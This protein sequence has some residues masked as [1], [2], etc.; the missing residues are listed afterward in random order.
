MCLL[1]RCG[2][3]LFVL[4]VLAQ[5]ANAQAPS[6]KPNLKCGAYCL[7]VALRALDVDVPNYDALEKELGLPGRL[8]YSMSDLARVAELHGAHVKGM[9]TH[10]EDL[11]SR[12]Q[13]LAYICLSSTGHFVC[14]YNV[15]GALVHLV[16]PPEVLSVPVDTFKQQWTGK[17]LLISDSPIRESASIVPHGPWAWGLLIATI[18]TACLLVVLLKRSTRINRLT[19]PI[20]VILSIFIAQGC[21]PSAQRERPRGELPRIEISPQIVDL[22]HVTTG[23]DSH[24]VRAKVKNVG[25][26]PLAISRTESSCGCTVAELP[27]EPVQPGATDWIRLKIRTGLEPGPRGSR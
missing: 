4:C 11:A 1:R 26:A 15:D 21:R 19:A 10:L 14:L 9:E 27:G 7:Y 20:L 5:L 12:R 17:V 22:G 6:K 24:E 16:D 13:R 18:A 3:L 23:P 8:G 25:T 2:G